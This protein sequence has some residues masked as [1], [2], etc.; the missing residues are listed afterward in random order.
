MAERVAIAFVC[1][2]A[3]VI[4]S[5][6]PSG[7]TIMYSDRIYPPVEPERVLL[8]FG[9]TD[10]EHLAIAG[11]TGE[12]DSSEFGSISEAEQAA[13][14]E[15][16]RRAGEI[17]AQAVVEVERVVLDSGTRTSYTEFGNDHEWY[18]DRHGRYRYRGGSGITTGSAS[19]SITYKVLLR[20]VAIRFTD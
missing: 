13:A 6:G 4:A 11:L 3:F 14:G 17:G 9:P 10:R 7:S 19:T 8:V 18:R 15:L 12:A 20:G 2:L 16:R 1:V 5:C